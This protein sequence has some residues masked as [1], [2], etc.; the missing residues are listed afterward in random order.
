MNLNHDSNITT[1][2]ARFRAAQLGGIVGENALW[3]LRHARAYAKFKELE[4]A[5]YAR[6]RVVEDSDPDVSWMDE[7]QMK[8]WD[9]ESYGTIT[10]YRLP[11]PDGF[12]YSDDEAGWEHA[13]SCFGH[14]GYKNVAD[15]FENC[16][17]IDEMSEA[18][19]C[20]DRACLALAEAVEDLGMK[21]LRGYPYIS[22]TA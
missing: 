10:E 2:Y 21:L 16:Y 7:R 19:N 20:F 1:L 22:K 18:V 15:P 17:V 8:E 13:D 3:C 12:E 5:G 11:M 14:M 9:G 6:I 4:D